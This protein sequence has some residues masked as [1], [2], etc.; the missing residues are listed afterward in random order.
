M[1]REEHLLATCHCETCNRSFHP[2]GIARHRAA[3]RDKA[4]NCTIEYDDGRIVDHFFA[5]QEV[6]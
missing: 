5:R 3:H 4:E 1:A 6:K 2:L